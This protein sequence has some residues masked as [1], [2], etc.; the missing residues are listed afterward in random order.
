[1]DGKSESIDVI[2][3]G[4]SKA[5][6]AEKSS[7]MMHA[8]V[9]ALT[10]V[11]YKLAFFVFFIFLFITSDIF[12]NKVLGHFSG[13]VEHQEPTLRGAT[14]QGL[15]MVLLFLLMDLLIRAGLI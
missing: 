2:D 3:D 15:F 10:K 6:P 1:M 8:V 7:D 5:K 13:A 14:L 9:D 12:V 4:A 11:N